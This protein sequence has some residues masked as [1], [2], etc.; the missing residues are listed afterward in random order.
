MRLRWAN[1]ILTFLRWRREVWL[2]SLLAM[3]RAVAPASGQRDVGHLVVR[4]DGAGVHQE[5]E[6]HHACERN[7]T[8]ASVIG[9]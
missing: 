4:T 8:H 3:L 7:T 5:G 9:S 1:S 6:S 2:S